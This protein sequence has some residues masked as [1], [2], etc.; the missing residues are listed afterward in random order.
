MK[1]LAALFHKNIAS[2]S[3]LIVVLGVCISCSNTPEIVVQQMKMEIPAGEQMLMEELLPGE[4]ADTKIE[5]IAYVGPTVQKVQLSDENISMFLLVKGNGTLK[6]DTSSFKLVSESIAIPMTYKSIN[7]EVEEGE[8][9]HF[10]RFTKKLSEQDIADLNGFSDDSKYDIYFTKFDD[11]EPY[12]EKIKSPNTV[13]RTV[14]PEDIIP[15]VALGTV[16]APGPDEVGA[17][18]HAMLDQLFL[19][20]TDNDIVVHADGASAEFTEYS[21][22]HIPIGS[23]HWVSVDENKRMYYLWMDFFLTKEGQEWLKTHK[24]ISTDKD[25]Y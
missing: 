1:F 7:I 16:E 11:C 5:H 23:S 6:T 18:K 22:L 2:I 20:L 8:E 24:P 25:E 14:L 15:R 19:G 10:V 12:T 17:H 4:I 21:L 3:I 13:S 9:L